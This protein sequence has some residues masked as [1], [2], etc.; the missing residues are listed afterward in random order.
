MHLQTLIDALERIAPLELASDWDNVG[1]LLGSR[2]DE[3][4]GPVLLTI[5]FTGAVL[6][7]AAQHNA[8]AVVAY[9]PP[10]FSP[11]KRLT[12]DDQVQRTLLRAA[13]QGLAIYSPHTALDAAPDAMS[14][15]LADGLLETPANRRSDADR[16][17]LIPRESVAKG[18]EVKI[19]TFVPAEKAAAVRDALASAGAG[20]IG[21][22]EV[23]SFSAPGTGTFLGTQG[24]HPA[25]GRVGRLEQVSE[26]RLEMV[27]AK[28]ALAL[29]IETLRHFHPYEE[30]AIDVYPL[31][32]QPV[33][34]A[35]P[36]RRLVLDR[37]ATPVQLAER[38]KRHLKIERI[39]VA[40]P[41]D[42]KAVTHVGVCPGAGA[43]L[44]DAARAQGCSV[45]VTGEMKHHEVLAA[46]RSGMSVILAG[47]TNT[48]R[49]YLPV[50]GQRLETEIPGLRCVVSTADRDPL[51]N[52]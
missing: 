28:A 22:Y 32:P 14:D 30:P 43:S 42:T 38:L 52:V 49:G 41:D 39:K 4:R 19:V 5:D 16:K 33:R 31:A 9:H 10:I 34:G 40:S 25:V 37:P 7:E 51:R 3:L 45:F 26:L 46:V 17:A 20:R 44:V 35:G 24:A 36:G 27:C 23:C 11:I 15:W 18:A 47:H 50:L 13:R 1:L 29:A 8:G 48:E 21:Q 6:H 2:E 12:G